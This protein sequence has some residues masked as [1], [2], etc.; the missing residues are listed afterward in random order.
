MKKRKVF[1]VA[2]LGYPGS[3]K[4]Y[5]SERFAKNHS[6]FHLNSDIIRLTMFPEPTYNPFESGVVFRMMDF[7]AGAFLSSGVSVIYDA[8]STLR[9][10]RKRLQQIAKKRGACYLLLRFKTPL[11][12]ALKR[13]KKRRALKSES[14]KRYYRPIDDKVLFDI[15]GEMEEPR[16]EH[17]I[18]VDGESPYQETEKMVLKEL[19]EFS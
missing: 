14:K 19:K 1:L 5:F 16:N 8:N 18:I 2:T 3:G 17:F 4:T 12:V 7:L 13:L 6:F 9:I 10:Y 15:K 11:P